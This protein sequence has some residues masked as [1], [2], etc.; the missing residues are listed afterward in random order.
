MVVR[1]HIFLKRV[2]QYSELKIR[3]YIHNMSYVFWYSVY[4]MK[5]QKRGEYGKGMAQLMLGPV[6][7]KWSSYRSRLP[8]A[9]HLLGP[10]AHPFVLHCFLLAFLFNMDLNS[11]PGTMSHI[12]ERDCAGNIWNK[13]FAFFKAVIL[14]QIIDRRSPGSQAEVY[15]NMWCVP[16][17]GDIRCMQSR[18][19]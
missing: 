8:Y 18:L 16:F 13:N 5:P 12:L 17:N 19:I 10:T 2:R 1:K 9:S 7:K 6:Q 3:I 15:H 4:N 11:H 14:S